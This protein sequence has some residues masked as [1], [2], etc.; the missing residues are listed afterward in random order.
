MNIKY[1]KT[2]GHYYANDLWFSP[3]Y[4]SLSN[5]ARDLLQC[6]LTEFKR[7]ERKTSSPWRKKK[8]WTVINNGDISFTEID[9][10]KLTGRCS[11]TY[12]KSRNK[13][14]EVGIIKQTY[15]GGMCRGD[16]ATYK[17]LIRSSQIPLMKGEERWRMYPEK[18]WTHEIPKP[19]KQ[20]VGTKTQWKKGQ[21]GRKIKA[22][23]QK[24]TLNGTNHPNESDP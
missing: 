10:K 4:Q 2:Q 22:T 3:A 17:I 13:L 24:H 18:N 19:K 16:R 15:R 12:L 23:L 1:K 21:S 8:R 6:L 20:L 9:F 7:N 11:S 5:S 14:M